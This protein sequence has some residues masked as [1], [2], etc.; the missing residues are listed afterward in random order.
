[1]VAPAQQPDP[2]ALDEPEP[3]ER[4]GPSWAHRRNDDGELDPR[5]TSSAWSKVRER[6]EEVERLYLLR[7]PEWRIV[8]DVTERFAVTDRQV[9]ADLRRVKADVLDDFPMA[10]V[11][12]I[13]A[14]LARMTLA[15][16]AKCLRA[17][18]AAREDADRA[19]WTDIAGKDLDRLAR[20]FGVN[21]DKV[22]HTHR[23]A[24]MS[25]PEL[26]RAITEAARQH[27]L[28]LSPDE[29]RL[30]LAAPQLADQGAEIL[31]AVLDVDSEERR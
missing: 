6:V 13:R 3:L 8:A 4:R 24:A 11:A 25:E 19:R 10:D 26:D 5:R 7:W 27:L 30:L 2:W 23:V 21:Q 14:E 20:W 31:D 22:D 18:E 12:K 17:S 16:Y 29:R 1:M 15:H 9:K 28:A